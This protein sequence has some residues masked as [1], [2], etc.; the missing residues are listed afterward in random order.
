MTV[1]QYTEEFFGRRVVEFRAGGKIK[2][3]DFVYRLTQDFEETTSQRELLD[4]F[5][6]KVGAQ[7][8]EALILGPW[9]EA[10]TGEP[11]AGYLEGLIAHKLPKLRALFVGDMTVEDSEISWINQADY[12]G[13][14]EAYP[15]LEVLRIRGGTALEL[16]V[17]EYNSLRELAIETGGLPGSVIES[18]A[19]ST[20]PALRK[21]ELWLGTEEY[22]FDADL[23]LCEELL[24]EIE[25]QRLEYLGL[26]NSEITDDLAAYLAKQPWLGKLHT[27]DLSMG[28]IGDAGAKALLGSRH[29]AGLKVLDLRHHY[30]SAPLVEKLEALPL[31]L[32]IDKAEDDPDE[33]YVQVGEK[34]DA[35]HRQR[36]GPTH[37][38]NA[39]RPGCGRRAACRHRVAG[40]PGA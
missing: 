11:P 23:D 8:L 29:L 5:L 32:L 10:S 20:M 25:P 28:T 14:I 39:C 27:L 2:D 17:T 38:T 24:T 13:L 31:E 1:D 6:G 22:G 9:A 33:R 35:A 3:R 15:R 7:Q 19:S 37:L 4:E 34:K 36:A 18:I 26:R 16:P 12:T 40:S 21:L 30:I